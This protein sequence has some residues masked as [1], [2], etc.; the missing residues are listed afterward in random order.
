[1]KNIY[2]AWALFALFGLVNCA[3]AQSG[4]D[5]PTT[6]NGPAAAS[7]SMPPNT[8]MSQPKVTSPPGTVPGRPASYV[9]SAMPSN[10]GMSRHKP[11]KPGSAG[12]FHHKEASPP[13][14]AVPDSQN[15]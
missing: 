2:I 11:K 1:M 5:S 8:G 12:I 7:S 10:T 13:A 4:S 6:G 3:N 14:E 15:P 9:T